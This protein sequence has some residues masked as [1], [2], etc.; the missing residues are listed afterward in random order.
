MYNNLGGAVVEFMRGGWK[1]FFPT[2]CAGSESGPKTLCFAVLHTNGDRPLEQ[3]GTREPPSEHT[4]R[5]LY[6]KK[7]HTTHTHR[8]VFIEQ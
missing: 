8:T 1:L 7:R 2:H 6:P 4:F 3:R 5:S